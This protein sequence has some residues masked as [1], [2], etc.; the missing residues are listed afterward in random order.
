MTNMADPRK[1]DPDV[2]ASHQEILYGEQ[3]RLA[4]AN[5]RISGLR[6]QRT[7]IHA[8]G[9]IKACAARVNRDLGILPRDLSQAVED[10]AM[11][12]ADGGY[13]DQFPVDV[14]QTG[15]GTSTN[16]NANEVIAALAARR[17]GRA[18]H[19]NDDVNRGQ[20]SND[21]IPTA[22]HV[23]AAL[24]LGRC[25]EALESLHESILARASE[26]AAV[27]KTGRTHLMDAVPMT[28]GQEL[29]GW[30]AQVEADLARLRDVKERL[31][32]LVQG[33]TAVGT[34][35]NA[36]LDFAERFAAA[37]TERTG[38]AFRPA[39]NAFAAI[40]AQDTAVELSGQLRVAAISLLKI[41]TDLRW[42]NSGPV[43]GLGEI[44]LPEMQ[45]GS[46]IMPGKVN[47]V[48]PEAVGMACVQVIGLDTAVALA[49]QDNRFQLATM[50][51]LIAYNLLQ[52]VALLT[53]ATRS[54]EE[55][56]IER[57]EANVHELTERAGRNAM[58]ATALTPRIGYDLATRI[59]KTALEQGRAVLDVARDLS[60]LSE[61]ELLKLLDPERMARPHDHAVKPWR[62]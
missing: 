14:F 55:Q 16:M 9:L 52:Q 11:D 51:P 45:P 34:G 38:L 48:I 39:S 17:L 19:P 2:P 58:L 44:R 5:F 59:A 24:A 57:F 40:G 54:L 21:V 23:G 36:H 20:S 4:I 29:S 32:A 1:T 61:E 42:M 3:T 15:S 13:D 49:A 37:M 26:H 53:G 33:G 41:A 12:V 25:M 28:L 10:A 31:L 22:I 6:F 50:L 56:A 7:M 60:G 35:L 8:L 43:S 47:P 27:V 30:A 62:A 46:S 18:V